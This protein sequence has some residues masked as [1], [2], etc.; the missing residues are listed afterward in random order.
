MKLGQMAKW[1]HPPLYAFTL[2]KERVIMIY[3]VYVIHGK[4]IASSCQQE[5]NCT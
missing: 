1:T 5:T 2:C 3:N 4:R